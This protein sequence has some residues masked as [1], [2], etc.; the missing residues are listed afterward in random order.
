M[1]SPYSKSIIVPPTSG[2][3]IFDHFN[4]F[5]LGEDSASNIDKISQI[6]VLVTNVNCCGKVISLTTTYILGDGSTYT[7][8]NGQNTNK[9]LAEIFDFQDTEY[10]L[11][12]EVLW[13]SYVSHI[14]ICA[15]SGR[16]FGPF[17]HSFDVPANKK[18]QAPPGAV[19]KALHGRSGS[20]L[21]AI[22]VYYE[23]E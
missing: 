18:F 13:E 19:I 12:I 16:C 8:T 2:G 23:I 22:G 1:P 3:G 14:K 20:W 6:Q 7:K 11:S 15:T 9:N 21:N 10:I 17:G 4:D 5:G